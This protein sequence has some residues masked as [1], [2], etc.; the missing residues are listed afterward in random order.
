M[1][2]YCLCELVRSLSPV[3]E[4][5]ADHEINIFGGPHTYP[6]EIFMILASSNNED[7]LYF[8]HL[9]NELAIEWYR[10]QQPLSIF[11]VRVQAMC[12][13]WTCFHQVKWSSIVVRC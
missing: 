7:F 1:V 6:T 5:T 2:Y 4:C 9:K 3:S 10:S 12:Q 8:E 11:H 13:T